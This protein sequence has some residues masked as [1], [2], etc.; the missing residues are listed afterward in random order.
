MHYI[1]LF[2]LKSNICSIVIAPSN[3]LLIHWEAVKMEEV[4]L[5][6]EVRIVFAKLAH[7]AS[8]FTF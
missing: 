1:L 5:G 8:V 6:R 3:V 7:K 2:T 4:S